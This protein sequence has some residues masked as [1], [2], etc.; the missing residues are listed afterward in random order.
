[1]KNNSSILI[2]INTLKSGGAEK[3]SVLLAKNLKRFYY[4]TLVVYYGSQT[5]KRLFDIIEEN[6]INVILL[7]GHHFKK[8]S[9]LYTLF[10][11]NKQSIL[12]SYL[13]TTN[14][15]NAYIG[16]ICGNKYRVG[17]IRSS[18]L[19]PL[20]M[21]LQRYL[22][23]KMLSHSVCNNF[24]GL[25]YM[26]RNGFNMQKTTV[27]HNCIEVKESAREEVRLSH[28]VKILSV[29]RFVPEKDY[30]CA[31]KSFKLL[32]EKSVQYS[33]DIKFFIV[34]YGKQEKYIRNLIE[35]F[36]LNEN[37]SVFINPSNVRD[38]YKISDIYLSTS[39]FEG[40]SNSIMEALEFSLPVIATNVGD[41]KCLVIDGENGFLTPV[42][43][44][45]QI[46]DKLLSLV[47]D[48]YCRKK[49]GRSG[50]SNL[51]ANFTEGPFT[52][53]YLRLIEHLI[54]EE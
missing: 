26:K 32:L 53:K 4:V 17:G 49:M 37:V 12:I 33:F 38:F 19:S 54:N 28:Q 21:R 25:F 40:L 1:M 29:G 6:N 9:Q 31:L 41:N 14:F 52:E 36:G 48:P 24:E 45:E 2:L 47:I 11:S 34:G 22:H 51:I 10:K 16:K 20:K 46:S 13:A 42:K 43:D 8:V 18:W 35:E 15:I 27:I 30:C 5:D 50:Y 3:Q 23:N 39:L 44:V 7:T